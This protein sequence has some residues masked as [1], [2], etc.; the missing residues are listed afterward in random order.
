MSGGILAPVAMMQG[1]SLCGA[2]SGSMLLNLEGV[3]TAAIAW[4][5]FKE[6]VDHRI[7]AGMVAIL[8]GGCVLSFGGDIAGMSHSTLPGSSVGSLLIAVACFLWALDNNLCRKVSTSDSVLVAMLK[9]L[10][11]GSVNLA[12]AFAYGLPAPPFVVWAPALLIGFFAYGLSLVCYLSAQ[13][14]LGTARTGAYFAFGP[15][16]GAILSLAFLHEP[17]GPNLAVA[18]VLM[19][20]G[21]WLH[22]TESH[23][24]SHL[25]KPT[26]HC[27]EHSHCADDPHH[28]HEHEPGMDTTKPHAHVHKHERLVHSHYHYPDSHHEHTH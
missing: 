18:T 26:E 2:A 10:T 5:V 8:I 23:S 16:A 15:F 14:Y 11:A 3:F 17:L 24:H 28:D 19:S 1:L 4:L 25:H 12:I 27:H 6:N 7:F 13:R 22:L 9:G 20:I 21:L